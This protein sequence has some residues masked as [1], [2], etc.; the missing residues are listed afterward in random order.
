MRS[1]SALAC[2]DAF[3]THLIIDQLPLGEASMKARKTIRD[4]DGDP[5]WLAYA[6]YGS[7]AATATTRGMS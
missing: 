2:A 1:D 4:L 6:V 7:P 3:Y 5:T